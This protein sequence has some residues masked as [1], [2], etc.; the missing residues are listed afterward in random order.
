M[1]NPLTLAGIEP[2][3]YRFVTQLPRS[4]FIS[5]TSVKFCVSALK[6]VEIRLTHFNCTV[7]IT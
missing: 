7:F 4:P 2:E 3:T 6:K 1:K 5:V